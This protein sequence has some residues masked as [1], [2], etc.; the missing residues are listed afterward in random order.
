MDSRQD[1]GNALVNVELYVEGGGNSGRTSRRC[2]EA[3]REFIEEAELQG[4]MP[5]IVA[6]GSRDSAYDD[7]KRAQGQHQN[8]G[9]AYPMLLVDAEEPVT[10]KSSWRHLEQRDGWARPAGAA[11][12]Q[13]HLMVQVMESWFLADRDTLKSFY[14]QDFHN[15][16]LP[17]NPK[18]EQ[19]PKRDVLEGLDHASR[20]TQ[21]GRYKENKGSH[22]F[23]ILAKLDAEKVTEASEFAKSFRKA[24]RAVT[25]A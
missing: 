19:V 8:A 1:R 12:E 10:A 17:P 5:R 6:C 24:L 25:A 13:C 3:F 14:G 15:A 9:G 7:F 11:D 21:K 4:R 18:I 2:R 20:D 16:A 22:S 23:G